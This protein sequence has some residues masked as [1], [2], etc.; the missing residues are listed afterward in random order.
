VTI[1]KPDRPVLK[2]S[3]SG[4]NLCPVFEWLKQDGHQPFKN[5][6]I[7]SGFQM[8]GHLDLDR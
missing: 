5:L 2:W 3:F 7:L 8:V 6:T 1:Q 4:Q